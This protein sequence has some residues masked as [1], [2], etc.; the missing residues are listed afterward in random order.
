MNEVRLS[1]YTDP[2]FL[3][4]CIYLASAWCD[5]ITNDWLVLFVEESSFLKPVRLVDIF[6]L[7][8]L[9]QSDYAFTNPLFFLRISTISR[10]YLKLSH[11]LFILSPD[12]MKNF[13]F[14]KKKEKIIQAVLL[15]RE[16]IFKRET[17]FIS[18][19]CLKLFF[20]IPY[21]TLVSFFTL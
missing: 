19:L 4:G 13:D 3:S 14:I 7:S 1:S 9:H 17:T 15:F 2:K 18:Y 8:S 20:S 6:M 11:N 16:I 12:G 10:Q 5:E 21:E